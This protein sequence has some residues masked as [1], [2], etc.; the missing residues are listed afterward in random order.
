MSRKLQ[1]YDFNGYA[2]AIRY[3]LH[4]GKLEF[5]D[6]RYKGEDWPIKSVKDSEYYTDF[7]L[8]LQKQSCINNKIL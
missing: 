7:L 6:V 2:E 5:E 3:L 4:Y 8:S 1:Y